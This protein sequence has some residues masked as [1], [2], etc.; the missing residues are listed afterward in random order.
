[1]LIFILSVSESD[2]SQS[3]LSHE[4]ALIDIAVD[5]VQSSLSGVL[6]HLEV[7]SVPEHWLALGVLRYHELV[8]VQLAQEVVVVEVGSCIDEWLLLVCFLHE[9]K[10][11]EEGVAELF[12]LHAALGLHVYHRQQVLVART[13]LRHEILQLCLLWNAGTIEVIGA[14]LESISVGEVDVVL[15]FAVHVGASLGG[16]EIHVCHLGVVTDGFP[17]HIALI[18]AEVDAVYVLTGV[19]ALYL[20]LDAE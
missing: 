10:E 16:L 17:E 19:L 2:F 3:V 4:P 5:A 1:M 9:V 8:A 15:V 13:A 11:L 20:C 14:H 12:R 7:S 6:P 18:V